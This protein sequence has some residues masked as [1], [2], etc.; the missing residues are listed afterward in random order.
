MKWMGLKWKKVVWPAG[1]CVE[2]GKPVRVEVDGLGICLVRRKGR[3]H[4]V[5]DRCPHQGSSFVGGWCEGEHLICPKHQMGFHLQT[6]LGRN[7][8]DQ[9]QVFPVEERAD[10]IY[11]GMPRRWLGLFGRRAG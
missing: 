8:A 5:L 9:A 11:I 1:P 10:G 3:L 7:G 6:G 4:A 2:D